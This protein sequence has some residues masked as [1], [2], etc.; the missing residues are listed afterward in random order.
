MSLDILVANCKGKRTVQPLMEVF[1]DTA[2]M[3]M[4]YG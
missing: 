4:V 3:C 1:H 2:T